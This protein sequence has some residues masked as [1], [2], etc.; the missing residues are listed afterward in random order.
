MTE[1][2]VLKDQFS[3]IKE[4]I[5]HLNKEEQLKKMRKEVEIQNL[6]EKRKKLEKQKAVMLETIRKKQ[7]LEKKANEI[8][9]HEVFII[10]H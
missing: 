2:K 4:S 7:D 5:E 6:K 1:E 3:I 10:M 8:L 9:I